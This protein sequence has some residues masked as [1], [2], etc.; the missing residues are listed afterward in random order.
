VDWFA[1]IGTVR[2][3]SAQNER[4]GAKRRELQQILTKLHKKMNI[5]DKKTDLEDNRNARSL[6]KTR[7]QAESAG[8]FNGLLKGKQCTILHSR[9][10]LP[11]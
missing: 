7:I 1:H 8:F 2:L 5:L 4:I 11:K 9:D 6:L 10:I 3:E